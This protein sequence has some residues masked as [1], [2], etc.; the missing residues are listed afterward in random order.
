MDGADRNSWPKAHGSYSNH[1]R[2]SM[3]KSHE[4]IFY[5]ILELVHLN[6]ARKSLGHMFSWGLWPSGCSGWRL[7]AAFWGLRLRYHSLMWATAFIYFN[8][9]KTW[10][11]AGFEQML[12][13]RAKQD[14]NE[15]GLQMV[16]MCIMCLWT[17]RDQNETTHNDGKVPKPEKRD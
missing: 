11:L 15:G 12:V 1:I 8:G 16:L 6:L 14:Q 3:R 7:L 4:S 9:K 2:M 5:R 17:K 10:R 13:S